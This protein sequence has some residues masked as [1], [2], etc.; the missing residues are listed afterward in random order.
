M[1]NYIVNTIH[2]ER[3]VLNERM[4]AKNAVFTSST[5]DISETTLE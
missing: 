4:S 3:Y 5:V 2:F 1:W